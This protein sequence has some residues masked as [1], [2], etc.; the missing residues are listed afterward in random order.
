MHQEKF[1]INQQPRQPPS[2]QIF[3]FFLHFRS[4]L[5]FPQLMP[6]IPKIRYRFELPRLGALDRPE[7]FRNQLRFRSYPQTFPFDR[8]FVLPLQLLQF[9]KFLTQ[10]PELLLLALV[11]RKMSFFYYYSI[12]IERSC[13]SY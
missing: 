4:Y 12:N 10:N 2:F 7:P 9:Q 5:Q 3:L 11:L 6:L 13:T 1:L 8:L